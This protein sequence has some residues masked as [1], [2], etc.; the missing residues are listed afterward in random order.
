M[1][2]ESDNLLGPGKTVMAG[3]FPDPSPWLREPTDQPIT[4]E[5]VE[6]NGIGYRNIC[7]ICY[8]NTLTYFMEKHLEW[9]KRAMLEDRV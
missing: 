8:A 2:D 6:E 9:H 4:K 3:A 5:Y 1:T 7:P